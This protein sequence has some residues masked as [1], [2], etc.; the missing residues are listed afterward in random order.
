MPTLE[1][2]ESRISTGTTIT[3]SDVHKVFEQFSLSQDTNY[4]FLKG[5]PRNLS[6]FSHRQISY[7]LLI[8]MLT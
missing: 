1:V 8:Y 7:Q 4:L 5:I 2:L 6:P 3:L